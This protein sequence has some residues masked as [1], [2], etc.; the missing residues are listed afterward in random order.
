MKSEVVHKICKE[1]Y[2]RFPDVKGVQPQVAPQSTPKA[3]STNAG[4]LFVL[5]FRYTADAGGSSL[6]RFVRV[7][8][9]EGGKILKITTSR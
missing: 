9:D 4:P 8:A 7:V 1:V 3:A 2:R 5:T 6:P